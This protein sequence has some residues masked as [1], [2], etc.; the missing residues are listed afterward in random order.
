MHEKIWRVLTQILLYNNDSIELIKPFFE[1]LKNE[2]INDKKFIPFLGTFSKHQLEV[3]YQNGIITEEKF[4]LYI[5][6]NQ[7][8]NNTIEE[9]ISGDKVE[10]LRK[11]IQETD[12]KTFKTIIKSF[13]EIQEMRI[14]LLQY[15]IMKRAIECFKYLLINGYD[16][17]NKTMEIQNNKQHCYKWDCMTLAI[18]FGNKE[19]IKILESRGIEKRR[20]P[21]HIEAAILSY[22]NESVKEYLDEMIEK[23]EEIENCYT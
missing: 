14:P 7:N 20:L 13:L 5:Q 16:D 18:Y 4:Q 6:K 11:L 8:D 23:N 17:P 22:R 9:I 21:D 1:N 12:I 15:C 3:L 19:I 10:E 2:N